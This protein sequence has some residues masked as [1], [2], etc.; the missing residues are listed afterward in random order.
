M[1]VEQFGGGVI[2]RVGV[3]VRKYQCHYGVG[4]LNGAGGTNLASVFV[5]P[6]KTYSS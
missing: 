2:S 4:C 6:P 1:L 3:A 5:L